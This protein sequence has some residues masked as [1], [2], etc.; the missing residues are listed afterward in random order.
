MVPG[1]DVQ[2]VELI[3]V[4]ELFACKSPGDSSQTFG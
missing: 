2:G 1:G 4:T 3:G